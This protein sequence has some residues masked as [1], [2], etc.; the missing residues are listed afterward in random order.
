MIIDIAIVLVFLYMG[1]IGFRRGM[2]F[3]IIHGSCTLVALIISNAYY[4]AI[5]RR[6]ELFV[7][8][9]KTVAY[10]MKFAIPFDQLQQRFYHIIAFIFI[11][12][13]VKLIL[14]AI[15]AVFDNMIKQSKIKVWSRIIG[16]ICS[17]ITS[18]IVVNLTLY[19]LAIYP[20]EMLQ[21]QLSF[22]LIAKPLTINI[23]LLSNFILKI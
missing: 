19:L 4:L 16:I 5:A 8:F 22:S 1:V 6:L 10:D 9:P 23:T 20:N 11:A 2:S 13:L 21:T 18:L 3:S 17:V 15:V 14:Y 7:P 12:V